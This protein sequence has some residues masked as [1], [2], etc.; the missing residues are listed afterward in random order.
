MIVVGGY[1]AYDNL[2]LDTIDI[3]IAQQENMLPITCQ[4]QQD[5]V[6]YLTSAYTTGYPRTDLFTSILTE[7]TSCKEG[8]CYLRSFDFKENRLD[9]A[10]C[11]TNETSLTY[12][13]TLKDLSSINGG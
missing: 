10:K 9:A 8:H 13:V 1:Y 6:M 4:V 3:C 12:K 11:Y 2:K 5:C 7:T